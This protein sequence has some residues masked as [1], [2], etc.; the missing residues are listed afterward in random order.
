MLDHEKAVREWA[1]KNTPKIELTGTTCIWGR[2]EMGKSTIAKKAIAAAGKSKKNGERQLVIID[3]L[4]RDGTGAMGVKK[5]LKAGEKVIVCNTAVRDEQMGAIL[6]ALSHSTPESPVYVVADEAPSYLKSYQPIIARAV[7]QGRHAGFG[8]LL[9]GQRAVDV[10][11]QY[12]TQSKQT[13]WMGLQ[14][15]TDLETAK[16][17]MGERAGVLP[18]LTQGQYI[19]WPLLE[20]K[21]A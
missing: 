14:D 2:S 5:A 15:H 6:F 8:I 16:K 9:I 20:T 1:T 10:Y 3:P 18:H 13:I 7:L 17:V 12:R 21:T 4:A 11:A 19:R